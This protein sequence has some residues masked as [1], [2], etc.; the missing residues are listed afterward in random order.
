MSQASPRQTRHLSTIA[1]YTTDVRYIK[2]ENTVAD[3]FS[4]IKIY[5]TFDGNADVGY[6]K[7]SLEQAEDELL[8]LPGILCS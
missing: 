3:C 7:F 1:E 2:E 6:L 8:Q 4:R 5:A